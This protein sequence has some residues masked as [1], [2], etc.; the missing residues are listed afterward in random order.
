M[1][2]F[3]TFKEKIL[4]NARTTSHASRILRH[5]SSQS[6]SMD[7][8]LVSCYQITKICVFDCGSRSSS[9]YHFP[10]YVCRLMICVLRPTNGHA[11]HATS[12]CVR[13]GQSRAKIT[14]RLP[15]WCVNRVICP[16]ILSVRVITKSSSTFSAAI[17]SSNI[18]QLLQLHDA[19]KM[20]SNYTWMDYNHGTKFSSIY[21]VKV[22]KRLVFHLLTCS[23]RKMVLMCL[24]QNMCLCCINL[25]KSHAWYHTSLT[26]F[27]N[28]YLP[29]NKKML[30]NSLPKMEFY[31]FSKWLSDLMWLYYSG[32]IP[33]FI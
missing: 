1:L 24:M 17:I 14:W 25:I 15:Q 7:T 8:E 3:C 18:I 16:E 13:A 19:I 11:S 20:K 2:V 23:V 27:P 9:G 28:Q 26:T 4:L 29:C 30:L 10:D 31:T 33:I 21:L 5:V 32:F 6:P 12:G 22:E